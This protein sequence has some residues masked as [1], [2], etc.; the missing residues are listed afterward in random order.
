MLVR[1]E[2]S[3]GRSGE[4]WALP[5]YRGD[6]ASTMGNEKYAYGGFT[7]QIPDAYF[8]AGKLKL[9][10]VIRQDDSLF[11][12]DVIEVNDYKPREKNKKRIAFLGGLNTAKGGEIAYRLM[13]HYGSKYDWYI[14]GGI[15][16]SNLNALEKSN[17]FK[18]GWYRRENVRAILRQYQI[19]AV[20]IFSIWA[21]TFCYTLSEAQLA[22]VP[23]IVTDIGALGERIKKDQ[24]GWLVNA[25][26]SEKE[27]QQKIDSIFEDEKLYAEVWERT[28]DF[29]HRTV[30]QMCED[31]RAVYRGL[32][33]SKIQRT[34]FDANAIFMAYAQGT[35]GC[36]VAMGAEDTAQMLRRLNELE[37]QLASIEQS[38]EY[39][40]ARFFNR[41]NIPFKRTIKRLMGF[42][43]R[44]YKKYFKK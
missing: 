35:S 37:T 8:A 17:V 1:I 38:M 32:D 33:A 10:L 20:C 24:T 7:V 16:N 5:V 12:S 41:E 18:L 30:A 22:G 31:Y 42:A 9:Q 15:G 36:A 4:Y 23:T 19:D 26:I 39:R 44:V 6:L 11:H 13:E 34:A 27:L 21:E 40:I 3:Q 14:I 25:D 29:K 2:D 28:A 43:Y